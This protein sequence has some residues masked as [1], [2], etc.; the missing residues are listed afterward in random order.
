[1]YWSSNVTFLRTGFFKKIYFIIETA[2]LLKRSEY[3]IL[4][5]SFTMFYHLPSWKCI[6]D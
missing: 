6:E 4:V 3:Y 1:M 5:M 2:C